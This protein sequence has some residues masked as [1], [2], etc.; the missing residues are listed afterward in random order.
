MSFRRIFMGLIWFA[1]CHFV[2]CAI[3]AVILLT[4]AENSRGHRIRQS[5]EE[6]VQIGFRIGAEA[7]N[8]LGG[9]LLFGSACFAGLGTWSACFQ[10]RGRE[11]L[12]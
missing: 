5:H 9:Y 4:N 10:G 8:S 6:Q 1:L 3:A 11:R 12:D 2:A 7:A